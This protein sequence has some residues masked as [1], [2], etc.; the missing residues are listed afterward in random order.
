MKDLLKHIIFDQQQRSYSHM[1][2]RDIDNNLLKLPEILVISGIRRCGKS[3]L[4]QQIRHSHKEQDYYFN[5][6]DDRLVI[7]KLKTS[8]LYTKF[9]LNCSANKKLFILTRYKTSRD[10]KGLFVVYTIMAVKYL[11][12]VPMP[13]C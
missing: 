13:I 10:G 2:E 8:N 6:D 9:L 12:P 3:V 4:L 5:F 11:L 7:L 1:V